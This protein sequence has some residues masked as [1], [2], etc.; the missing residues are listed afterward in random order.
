LSAAR[1][2]AALIFLGARSGAKRRRFVALTNQGVSDL[3]KLRRV[4]LTP[5][6]RRKRELHPV[7]DWIDHL[8]FRARVS[9]IIVVF[10]VT[11]VAMIDNSAQL[12]AQLSQAIF[13]SAVSASWR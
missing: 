13:E 10:M 7:R 11:M 8:S 4:L 5:S 6:N 1:Q 9:I 12:L 2:H 3:D